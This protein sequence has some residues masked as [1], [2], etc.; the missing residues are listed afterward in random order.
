[1]LICTINNCAF[2]IWSTINI[3]STNTA[4]R[5]APQINWENIATSSN[6]VSHVGG[7]TLTW[8][9]STNGFAF[10]SRRK[11]DWECNEVK[12]LHFCFAK[13]VFLSARE[14]AHVIWQRSLSLPSFHSSLIL[15]FVLYFVTVYIIVIVSDFDCISIAMVI[16]IV[17]SV[18]CNSIYFCGHRNFECGM[19]EEYGFFMFFIY[20]LGIL[21]IYSC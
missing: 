6:A 2:D 16:G 3:W 13:N 19:E 11:L 17:L 9:T 8:A 18:L 4:L 10:L 20:Y 15:T 5:T 12:H 1:M 14:I 7:E 21:K